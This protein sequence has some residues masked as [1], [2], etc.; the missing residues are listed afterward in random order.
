MYVCMYIHLSLYISN[1]WL[2]CCLHVYI[3]IYISS[4]NYRWN[5]SGLEVDVDQEMERHERVGWLWALT[6][7][8]RMTLRFLEW[9]VGKAIGNPILYPTYWMLNSMV[10][11]LSLPSEL[12]N[13]GGA[14]GAAG[15][16]VPLAPRRCCGAA[17]AHGGGMSPRRRTGDREIGGDDDGI[18]DCTT[19]YM[20][21][22]EYSNRFQ[23]NPE[24]NQ[25]VFSME[26]GISNT[27]PVT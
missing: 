2:T 12:S 6:E 15:V 1:C 13:T 24:L 26:W 16:S 18:G 17:S 23:G 14:A 4:V 5:T 7:M 10:S 8:I 19:Q 27:A 20:G 3:Y 21:L 22:K 9:K 25:P 11:R